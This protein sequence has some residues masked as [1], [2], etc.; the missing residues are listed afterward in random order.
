MSTGIYPFSCFL[1]TKGNFHNLEIVGNVRTL[2]GEPKRNLEKDQQLETVFPRVRKKG[3]RD[4]GG[5]SRRKMSKSYALVVWP[6]FGIVW[7]VPK[8]GPRVWPPPKAKVNKIK[9]A[10]GPDI[11][12]PLL[13]FLQRPPSSCLFACLSAESNHLSL[14]QEPQDFFKSPLTLKKKRICILFFFLFFFLRYN[15]IFVIM[16]RWYIMY[17]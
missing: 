11:F 10:G 7:S 9:R 8:H 2:V 14:L 16:L 5:R 4:A 1:S 3:K 6:L 12:F 15:F 13:P 17:N